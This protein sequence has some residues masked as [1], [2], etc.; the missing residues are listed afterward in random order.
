[1]EGTATHVPVA[2]GVP[3][4]GL[5]HR[6]PGRLTVAPLPPPPRPTA[7]M[8]SLPDSVAAGPRARSHASQVCTDRDPGRVDLRAGVRCVCGV[9]QGRAAHASRTFMNRSG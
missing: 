9:P 4:G 8:V 2:R 7:G 5:H 3:S 6:R 1:M